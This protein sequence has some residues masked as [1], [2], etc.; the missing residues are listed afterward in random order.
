MFPQKRA[1]GNRKGEGKFSTKIEKRKKNNFKNVAI[2]RKTLFFEKNEESRSI[3]ENK[4]K[5]FPLPPPP[6]KR[7]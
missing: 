2:P 6:K 3:L 1:K 5:K 7:K 4:K